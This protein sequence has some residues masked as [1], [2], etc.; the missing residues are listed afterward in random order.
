MEDL[1]TV[2][3]RELVNAAHLIKEHCND[4][5]CTYCIFLNDQ[6]EGCIVQVPGQWNLPH[7]P[8]EEQ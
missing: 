2:K 6:E 3:D 4:N 8:K 7:M 1:K 5:G